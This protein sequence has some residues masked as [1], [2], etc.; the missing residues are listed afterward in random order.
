MVKLR[1]GGWWGFEPQCP[2][3]TRGAGTTG[4]SVETLVHLQTSNLYFYKLLK[5]EHKCVITQWQKTKGMFKTGKVLGSI[6]AVAR[7]KKD[8]DFI[9]E[10]K[11]E[12]KQLIK[13]M[14]LT[15][16][17][18]FPSMEAKTKFVWKHTKNHIYHL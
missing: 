6:Q 18:Q 8:I 2:S 4:V 16:A 14:C 9:Q 15:L 1:E 12:Q 11:D 10:Q 13:E 5:Y 17:S 7:G 3:T